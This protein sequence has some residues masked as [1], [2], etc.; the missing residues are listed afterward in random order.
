MYIIVNLNA[1]SR[2]HFLYLLSIVLYQSERARY[3]P[4]EFNGV[5]CEMRLKEMRQVEQVMR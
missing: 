1:V 4:E 3:I 2:T 5:K